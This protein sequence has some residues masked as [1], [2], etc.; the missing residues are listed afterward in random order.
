MSDL[1]VRLEEIQK[2]LRLAAYKSG[3]GNVQ[4]VAVTKTVS[5]PL[6]A[7]A[8]SLGLSSF[9]ENRV[10]EALP[11]VIAFPQA[12]WHF[13]GGLQTNKVKEVVGRFQLIQSLDRWKLA[14]ALHDEAEAQGI[15]VRVLVQV[16]IGEEGQ[17]GGIAPGELAD[18]LTDVAGLTCL[19]VE[20][21]MTVPPVADDPEEVRP[22]FKKMAQ[23]FI[24][25][26]I[27][28]VQ[29]KILSMGMS[30]DFTVAVEEGATLVRVGSALFGERK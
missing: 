22:Y 17:K 5:Q 25:C 18:F 3:K 11:K 13:I 10:Q 6:I 29:M 26:T 14:V 30:G 27:P 24:G 16:N 19:Q 7:E 9:G 12:D 28:G 15:V 2:Q 1:S 20:G 8:L 4:L 21:L 23:L